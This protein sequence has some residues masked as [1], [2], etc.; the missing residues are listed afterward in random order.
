[1]ESLVP[2][3]ETA[4]V[5]WHRSGGVTVWDN[6]NNGVLTPNDSW[7][8]YGDS[9]EDQEFIL[10]DPTFPGSS[11]RIRAFVRATDAQ[12][13]DIG[14]EFYEGAALLGSTSVGPFAGS[15]TNLYSGWVNVVKTAAELAD[16][17]VRLLG[18]N[19]T[20]DTW[21]SEIEVHIEY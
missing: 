13:N 9:T 19:T 1:M 4:P 12:N 20:N 21:L 8:V 11:V 7:L 16:L 18:E 10:T 14:I 5:D 2:N 3:G 15:T 6:V 17:R